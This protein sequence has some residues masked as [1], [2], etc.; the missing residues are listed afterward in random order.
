MQSMEDEGGFGLE[1]AQR[2]YVQDFESRPGVTS[3]DVREL[4][5]DLRE[6]VAEG[7]KAGLTGREAFRQAIAQIGSPGQLAAEFVRENPLPLWRERAFWMVWAAVVFTAWNFLTVGTSVW[8]CNELYLQLPLTTWIALTVYLPVLLGAVWLARGGVSEAGWFE[9]V[10]CSRLRTALA[11]FGLLTVATGVRLF[12]PY[13]LQLPDSWAWLFLL[14]IV[15]GPFLLAAAGILL[16]RPAIRLPRANGRPKAAVC[17]AWRERVFWMALG[18]L[19]VGFWDEASRY[20]VSACFYAG[21][22]HQSSPLLGSLL[23]LAVRLSPVVA[24]ILL[25]RRGFLGSALPT[26]TRLLILLPLIVC[27]GAWLHAGISLLNAQ[28]GIAFPWAM[29]WSAYLSGLQ[30]LWPTGLAALAL[31]LAPR[32]SHTPGDLG[33]EL[34]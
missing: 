15:G 21:E 14:D 11:A 32:A 26:R 10:L 23:F 8:I 25:A 4:E 1:R 19:A 2:E 27:A 30:W 3:E 31:W 16:W 24:V 13:P 9:A 22:V 28:Q 7:L 18:G 29:F 34:A 33:L 12:G 6:R 20:G 5:S 17:N